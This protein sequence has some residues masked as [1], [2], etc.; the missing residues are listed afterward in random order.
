MSE[1][2]SRSHVS[3]AHQ[4]DDSMGSSSST[5]ESLDEMGLDAFRRHIISIALYRRGVLTALF[6]AWV[7]AVY[8]ISL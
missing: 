6:D 3:D 7:D 8:F 1:E 4:S 2:D 5:S